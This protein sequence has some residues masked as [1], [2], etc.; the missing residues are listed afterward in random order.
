MV[1]PMYFPVQ[2]LLCNNVCLACTH[3]RPEGQTRCGDC[4]AAYQR[5][6]RKTRETIKVGRARRAGAEEMRILVID[7]FTTHGSTEFN[8]LAVAEIVRLLRVD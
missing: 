7:R 1:K 8:G 2:T 3:E 5:D 6:Y 4:L